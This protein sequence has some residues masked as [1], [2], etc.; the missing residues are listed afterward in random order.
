MSS[1]ADTVLFEA[2]CTPAR[3]LGQRGML[4]LC[5]ALGLASAVTGGLF[6]WLGAWPVLGFSGGEAML[7]LGLLALHRRWAART[8]EVLVLTEGALTIR[9]TDARGRREELVLDP[10]WTR[11]RLEERPGRVSLLVL[12]R[13]GEAVEIGRLLGEDQKRDLAAALDAALRRWREPVFDNP[14]LR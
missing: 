9:R 10:Y 1:R 3:S 8:A 14:Q 2:I 13:R 12:R 7:V 5:L 11:L 4:A 6:L